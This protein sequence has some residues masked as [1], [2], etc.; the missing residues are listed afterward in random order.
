M[1]RFLAIVIVLVVLALIINKAMNSPK[2]P[3]GEPA[4][5][6]EEP[7]TPDL[8]PQSLQQLP[9]QNLPQKS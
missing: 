9:P 3:E 5:A 4:S 1:G 7:T 8:K 2:A 6:V